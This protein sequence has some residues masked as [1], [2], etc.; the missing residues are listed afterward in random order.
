MTD[1]AAILAVLMSLV[2]GCQSEVPSTTATPATPVP[3]PPPA[4]PEPPPRAVVEPPPPPRP[5]WSTLATGDEH[6]C[7][8]VRIGDDPRNR[9]KCWGS[10]DDGQLGLDDTKVRGATR[11]QMGDALPVV[12]LP[13]DAEIVAIDAEHDRSCALARDG[14][15]WCWGENVFGALGTGDTR[16]RG[17]ERGDMASLGPV[18]LPGKVI[19]FS[20][21]GMHSCALLEGGAVHCWGGADHHEVGLGDTER[22]GDEPGELGAALPAV[23]L[24]TDLHAVAVAAGDTHTCVLFAHGAIKCFGEGRYGVL[25]IDDTRS[26]GADARDMGDALPFVSLGSFHAVEVVSGGLHACARSN[27]HRV[28]CWGGNRSGQLGLGHTDSPGG[29]PGQSSMAPPG[30][31]ARPKVDLGRDGTVVALAAGNVTTCALL[32]R[33]RDAD[34]ALDN[35]I[36][37]WGGELGGSGP[38]QMGDALPPLALGAELVPMAIAPSGLY[39]CA[40]VVERARTIGASAPSTGR[41]KCWGTDVPGVGISHGVGIPTRERSEAMGDRLPFVDLGT[42]VRVVVPSG[43]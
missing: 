34:G 7:A 20:L 16:S 19:A 36:K 6:T 1:R 42:D 2:G 37:C 29:K 9:V 24:G 12:A 28:V 21:G 33:G 39:D 18:D 5:V 3:K 26:R 4:T 17:G 22:R 15:L 30:G 13:E 38:D 41:V 31:D 11:K 23:A 27:D 10:N 40:L 32:E 43:R 8:L 35:I 25:G 14:R